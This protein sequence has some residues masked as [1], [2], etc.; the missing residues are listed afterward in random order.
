MNT[1]KRSE[2]KLISSLRSWIKQEELC[3]S[4][5]FQDREM[6]SMEQTKLETIRLKVCEYLSE[7]QSK[8]LEQSIQNSLF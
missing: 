8:R 5:F 7:C 2:K 6:W 3:E 1:L 4:L